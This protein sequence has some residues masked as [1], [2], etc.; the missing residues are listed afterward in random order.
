MVFGLFGTASPFAVQQFLTYV[1]G[2][3]RLLAPF[4]TST[5]R[6]L[7]VGPALV[8]FWLFMMPMRF[9]VGCRYAKSTY[10]G[11]TPSYADSVFTKIVPGVFVEGGRIKY[12]K[13]LT[14]AG[15]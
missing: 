9:V 5:R 13:Q 1:S 12:V 15:G 3:R 8:P 4:L 2:V 14:I 11:A 10:G 6:A 7:R